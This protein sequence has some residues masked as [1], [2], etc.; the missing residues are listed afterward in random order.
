MILLD[1]NVLSEIMRPKPAKKVIAWLDRHD[2]YAIS[3]V[4]QAEILLGLAL[5]PAGKRRKNLSKLAHTMFREDFTDRIYPFDTQAAAIYANV[6]TERRRLGLTTSTE[7]GQIAATA[8]RYGCQ[9][10]TRNIKDFSDISNL[11]LR[12]P[13]TDK[14]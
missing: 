7:D 11:C 8:L 14:T 13:W 5:L 9:L 1:T 12:N 6:I 4:T 3:V 10:A 2:N